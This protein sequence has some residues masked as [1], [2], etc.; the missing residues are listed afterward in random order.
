MSLPSGSPRRIIEGLLSCNSKSALWQSRKEKIHA[1]SRANTTFGGLGNTVKKR[2]VSWEHALAFGIHSPAGS[3][4]RR[5]T[6]R[7][8]SDHCWFLDHKIA[9]KRERQYHSE[10]RTD[11]QK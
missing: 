8:V 2:D 1:K 9:K 3:R 5:S 6:G 10:E 7:P 4:S 11:V